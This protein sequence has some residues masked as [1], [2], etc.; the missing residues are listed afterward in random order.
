[1]SDGNSS[2]RPDDHSRLLD[3]FCR[4]DCLWEGTN[5]FTN[6]HI[7]VGRSSTNSEYELRPLYTYG[8]FIHADNVTL[9]SEKIINSI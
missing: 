7:V 2:M 8:L 1:M 9:D 4:S 6:Q 3:L 5:S